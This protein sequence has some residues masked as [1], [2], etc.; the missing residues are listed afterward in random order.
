MEDYYGLNVPSAKGMQGFAT[1]PLSHVIVFP[2]RSNAAK[3][4][5][6]KAKEKRKK[7]ACPDVSGLFAGWVGGF[8]SKEGRPDS[9]AWSRNVRGGCQRT[10]H[11]IY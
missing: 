2:E 1:Y 4:I 7:I 8:F 6:R 9:G 5:K 10:I 11:A 3:Q